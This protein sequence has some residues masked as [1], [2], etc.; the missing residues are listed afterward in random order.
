MADPM[1]GSV[2]PS[3]GIA[4]HAKPNRWRRYVAALLSVGI[5]GLFLY[6]A[7]RKADVLDVREAL[8][9][10][11]LRW[12]LPIVVIALV[13]F[14]LR[15]VRWSWMFPP[16]SRPTVRQAFG[17]FMI[18]T[19]TNNLVPGRLGD[20]ARAGMIS[21]LVPAI[22]PSGALATVVL[23]KVVD[24]LTLLAFLG[25]ALFIA[26]LPAWLGKTS[27][28]GSLVFLGLLLIL[29]IINAHGKAHRT[30]SDV[31]AEQFC[32]GKMVA[33]MQRI[34]QRFALGLNVLNNKRQTLVVLIV[35]LA[36]WLLEF[37]IMF[38]VLLMFGLSLPFVAAIV[39]GVILSIGMMLPAAPGAVG[40]YQFFTV[41]GLQLYHVP[42]SQALAIA[43]FLN[44]FVFANS[45]VLG[46][47]AL[48]VKG[49]GWL[50]PIVPRYVPKGAE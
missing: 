35:T 28:I 31:T 18:G 9:T 26:P 25:L 27:A 42:D 40:T 12:L 3:C 39:T 23:E 10:M 20:V 4:T 30:R 14:W 19:L 22:G 43:V 47:I 49:M 48:S 6:L 32:F 16:D 44:L 8:G 34:L 45:T 41:T 11:N 50:L 36:I 2:T 15:A 5:S 21:R 17:T 37:S 7:V 24:G 38:V 29:L 1:A 46:L 13:D 33:A